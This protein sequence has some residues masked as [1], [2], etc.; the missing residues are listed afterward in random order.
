MA[1]KTKIKEPN[2][3]IKNFFISQKDLLLGGATPQ[4]T[5]SLGLLL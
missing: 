5:L 4:E 3:E 2:T 1:L